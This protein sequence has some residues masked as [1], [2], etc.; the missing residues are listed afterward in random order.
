METNTNTNQSQTSKSKAYFVE[1]RAYLSKDKKYLT[2]VLPGNLIIR[3]PCNFY[4]AV[5][6]LPWERAAKESA[7]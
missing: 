4:K 6:G 7:S 5:M 1:P 2:L 3:K